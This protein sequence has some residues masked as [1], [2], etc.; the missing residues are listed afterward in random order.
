MKQVKTIRPSCRCNN[1]TKLPS[2]TTITMTMR[3][4]TLAY[5]IMILH[6]TSPNPYTSQWTCSLVAISKFRTITLVIA[7]SSSCRHNSNSNSS[8]QLLLARQFTMARTKS[9]LSTWLHRM[10]AQPNSNSSS[11]SSNKCILL[12]QRHLISTT[13]RII[14]WCQMKTWQI[15]TKEI[16]HSNRCIEGP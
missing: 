9:T 3:H 6:T 14:S 12:H 16:I 5:R 8:R 10:P 2:I 13:L 4:H 1:W 15:P 7:S 11:T